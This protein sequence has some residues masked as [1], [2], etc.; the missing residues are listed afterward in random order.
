MN[1]KSKLDRVAGVT[2]D[3]DR[4]EAT[5]AQWLMRHRSE[6]WTDTDQQ[7]LD[8]WL[9]ESTFHRVAFLRLDVVWQQ[10]GRLNA[11]GAG[12]TAG[13][14]P[15]P[16]T[17]SSGSAVSAASAIEPDKSRARGLSKRLSALAASVFLA[18]LGG[19]YVIIVHRHGADEYMTAVGELRTVKLADGSEVTLNTATRI[20]AYLRSRERRI[21]MDAG[22]AYFVVARDPSRPFVINVANTTV[23]AV[24]TQFSVRQSSADVQVLVT[25]GRVR[26]SSPSAATGLPTMVGAGTV[27]QIMNSGV[28][29]RPAS[30]TEADQLSAWRSG[31]LIFRDTPLAQAVAELNRYQLRELVIADP[32]IAA[33]RIGGK[34]RCANVD[35]FLALLQEGFPVTV[36][37]NRDHIIL[38]Q[39]T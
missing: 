17:W 31:F 27:A 38:K 20:R 30:P 13:M 19:I 36:E 3:N 2:M 16:G 6:S 5:A 18:V 25:E 33:I 15:P 29:V 22:E 8:A 11:L 32:A 7:E 26:L 1:K 35:S 34:F 39:R 24:G 21:D 9:H 4:I 12:V 10:I 28:L 23:M 14:V 37:R